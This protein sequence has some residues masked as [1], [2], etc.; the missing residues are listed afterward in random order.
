MTASRPALALVALGA[1]V[2][3]SAT[4]VSVTAPATGGP[5]AS[6]LYP[7]LEDAAVVAVVALGALQIAGGTALLV[8]NWG[9]A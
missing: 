1:A 7:A 2:V 3:C 4:T 5:I 8:T 6:L 9:W